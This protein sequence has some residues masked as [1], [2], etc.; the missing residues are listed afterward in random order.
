LGLPAWL[1]KILEK[2]MKAFWS[3]GSD[4]VQ[5]GKC[6]VVWS[7][8]QRPLDRDS[9][10]IPDL[11]LLGSALRMRWLWLKLTNLARPWLALMVQDD[12]DSSAFLN[13][14]V[15]TILGNGNSLMFL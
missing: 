6:L 12:R 9:L 11:W 7:S 3:F 2:I 14:S 1:L 15:I 13:S 10:G 8:I 5:G 4:M